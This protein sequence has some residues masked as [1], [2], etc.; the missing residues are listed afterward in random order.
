MPASLSM[1]PELCHESPRNKAQKLA[2]IVVAAG[3][4]SAQVKLSNF[5][6]R[7]SA[8]SSETGRCFFQGKRLH[9]HAQHCDLHHANTGLHLQNHATKIISRLVFDV[10]GFC[11][12]AC[13]VNSQGLTLLDFGFAMSLSAQLSRFW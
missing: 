6:F 4:C 13:K 11:V 3:L 12:F 10:A 8:Q 7:E 1:T 2:C 5:R 9:Q